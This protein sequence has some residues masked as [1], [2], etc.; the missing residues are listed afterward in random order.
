MN[1]YYIAAVKIG[2]LVQYNVNYIVELVIANF[3]NNN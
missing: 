1:D 2:M 3:S